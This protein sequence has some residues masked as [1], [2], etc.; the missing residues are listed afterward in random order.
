M[1]GF[2]QFIVEDEKESPHAYAARKHDEAAAHSKSGGAMIDRPY[3]DAFHASFATK[4]AGIG[5]HIRANA[6]PYNYDWIPHFGSREKFHKTLAQM[7]RDA[8][9]GK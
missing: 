1:I 9:K 7:H 8:D 6:N 5:E 4:H 3:K 2:T